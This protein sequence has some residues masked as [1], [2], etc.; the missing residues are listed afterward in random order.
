VSWSVT[1]ALATILSQT[2]CTTSVVAT[3]TAG[4]PF[5][6][7]ASSAGGTTSQTV[8]VKRDATAP[9]ATVTATPAPNANGWN[10]GLV[11]V[12]FTGTDATS[13]IASCSAV[14]TVST[15]GAAQASPVGTCTD[16]AG[17][18]SAVVSA[19]VSID[20]T[21]P[22]VAISAPASGATY[23]QGAAVTASYTC[24]D[25]LSG[26]ASCVGSVASG[27][28]VNTATA[29]TF[30]FTVTAIDKAGNATASSVNYTVTGGVTGG[31]PTITPTVVG[32]LGQNG[33]YTSDVTVSFAVA[34]TGGELEK[35]GCGTRTI[36]QNTAGLVLTCTASNNKGT[37][38]QMVTIKRDASAP[39]VSF[40][41]SPAAN[42]FDWQHS[43][44]V[45]SFRCSS[46]SG[47][48]S[49]PSPATLAT[50]GG[51]QSVSGTAVN[52][53]GL[54]A[55]VT[56]PAIN[57]DLTPPT[58][59]LST[60]ANGA[61]YA[62]NSVVTASYACADVLSGVAQCS[63]TLTNGA[64]LNT[65]QRATH[66]AFTVTGKDKAGNATQV[67]YYYSVN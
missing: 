48:A 8:T 55:N 6:C 60:P 26:I 61:V 2:G 38:S 54:S 59:T 11:T 47:I 53:A 14:V 9:V 50:E 39:K 12:S 25:T 18:V 13:G 41:E 21:P 63:G 56:S 52:N 15:E 40:S 7:S 58:V 1:D 66:E 19:T 57:I 33:W 45:I 29:G 62:L 20:K 22:T 64:P 42:G 4:Q 51:A 36:T 44:V 3:D 32:T 16:V 34:P 28:A 46:I 30:T 5:T 35:E 37:T 49:C 43:A 23:P 31:A 17:N 24:A 67:T 65:T 27:A 10:N